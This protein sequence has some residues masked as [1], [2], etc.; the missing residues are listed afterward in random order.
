MIAAPPM[1]PEQDTLARLRVTSENSRFTVKV[2]SLSWFQ[3]KYYNPRQL[4]TLS[5]VGPD[6]SIKALR[7]M[8]LDTQIVV[9]FDYW[10]DDVEDKTQ[11]TK[12]LDGR[13]V[14]GY[15]TKVAR[16]MRGATHLTAQAKVEGLLPEISDEALWELFQ[17][18]GFDTP[19]LR[20]WVPWLRGKLD[21]HNLLR[22]CDGY[23]QSAGLMLATS[24][25]LDQL[26]SQGVKAGDLEMKGE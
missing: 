12:A 21:Y 14:L 3:D 22:S 17:S 6:T 11:I 13:A 8:L 19:L 23:N 16:L 26:V 18:D 10:D 4:M 25:S 1:T 2:E 24:G 20:A 15:T 5:C 9:R 7:A